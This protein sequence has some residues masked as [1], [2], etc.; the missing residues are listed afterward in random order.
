MISKIIIMRK[1]GLPQSSSCSCRQGGAKW[2]GV[3]ASKVPSSLVLVLLLIFA[4]SSAQ[5]L[6]SP[7]PPPSRRE[8]LLQAPLGAAFTYG[9]GRAFYNVFQ[10][11]GIQHPAAHE[12]RVAATITTTL[13]A[14]AAAAG[15]SLP[16][17]R[18]PL[19][20]L[21]VGVGKDCR[22]ARRGLYT[23]G[24]QALAAGTKTTDQV[25]LVGVDLQI[26]TDE[27][28][29]TDARRVLQEASSSSSLQVD[30]QVLEHSITQPLPFADG[31]FDAIVCCLTLCSVDDPVAAVHE[32]NRLLRPAGGALGFVEHVAVDPTVDGNDLQWLEQQQVWLDPFQQRVAD[33]CHLHRYTQETLQQGLSA[34]TAL[35]TQERFVVNAMWPV[36]MQACGVFQKQIV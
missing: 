1:R 21:E 23:P 28:V 25:Q 17:R 5:A 14:A 10:N 15:T 24:L 33:N 34:N 7:S 22:V 13:T 19:R 20:I 6:S 11:L 31:Y 26:P 12:D 30:L 9:Y 36:S 29:L 27:A 16:S 18:R 3:V 32:M 8:W 35:L 2:H 4:P